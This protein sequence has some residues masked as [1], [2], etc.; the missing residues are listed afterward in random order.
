M[1]EEGVVVEVR[2]EVE[3]G[4]RFGNGVLLNLFVGLDVKMLLRFDGWNVGLGLRL[5]D[6]G[7]ILLHITDVLLLSHFYLPVF[8]N[9]ILGVCLS[10][11]DILV[12]IMNFFDENSMSL[13]RPSIVMQ[14]EDVSSWIFIIVENELLSN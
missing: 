1:D 12:V 10:L 9:V 8:R 11:E 14:P 6:F 13:D 5:I 3:V 2:D 7:N 4:V